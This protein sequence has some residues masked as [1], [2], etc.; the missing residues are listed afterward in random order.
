MWVSVCVCQKIHTRDFVSDCSLF[1]P[2]APPPPPAFPHA[3]PCVLEPIMSVEVVAP[4]EFQGVVISGMNRRRGVISGTDATEGYFTLYCEVGVERGVEERG[5]EGRGKEERGEEG[6]GKEERGWHGGEGEDSQEGLRK[7]EEVGGGGEVGGEMAG[8]G[9]GTKEEGERIS[10]CLDGCH[11]VL[12]SLS[13]YRYLSIT[14]LGM[15]QS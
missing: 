3:L 8:R 14:C 15:P 9:R 4:T 2:T 13:C 11:L 1:L 6:R 5:E 7:E 12:L 10:A